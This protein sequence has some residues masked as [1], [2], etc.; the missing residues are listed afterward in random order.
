MILKQLTIWMDENRKVE[1]IYHKQ[2]NTPFTS[3]RTKEGGIFYDYEKEGRV[4]M[5]SPREICLRFCNMINRH[6]GRY[7]EIHEETVKGVKRISVWC[8]MPHKGGE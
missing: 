4:E 5:Q 6:E 7:A 1:C 3:H 2:M 8:D